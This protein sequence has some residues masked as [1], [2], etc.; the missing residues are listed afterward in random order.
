LLEARY[1]T[2]PMWMV[3]SIPVVRRR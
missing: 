1:I 3:G 2:G